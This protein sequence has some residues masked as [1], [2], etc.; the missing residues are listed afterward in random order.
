[1]TGVQT[2][3]L[4]ICFPVTISKVSAVAVINTNAKS[5]TVEAGSGGTF[6]METDEEN[7][8]EMTY[9]ASGSSGIT[10][11]D[12]DNIDF[13]TGNF[14]LRWKGSLPDWTPSEDKLLL[15]KWASSAGY[16]LSVDTSTNKIQI[17][18][19]ATTYKTTVANT[20]VDGTAYEIVAVVTNKVGPA[21]S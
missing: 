5:V 12:D 3:A 18:I 17:D 19:N 7:S 20:F 14:T 6:E 4:P 21:L 13:G 16:I 9:A 15:L 2:C 10:V 11:A 1:M 8:V